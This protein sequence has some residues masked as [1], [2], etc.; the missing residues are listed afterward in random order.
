[1]FCSL[2]SVPFIL[3]LTL[4]SFFPE[5]TTALPQQANDSVDPNLFP[6]V[7]TFFTNF[8]PNNSPNPSNGLFGYITLA[9]QFRCKRE[10]HV[11][12]T[13]PI[14]GCQQIMNRNQCL[15][16]AYLYNGHDIKCEWD[17]G[18]CHP[19]CSC[20]YSGQNKGR[21][22]FMEDS[23]TFVCSQRRIMT[24]YCNQIYQKDQCLQAKVNIAG[25][26]V[27]C[28]WNNNECHPQCGCGY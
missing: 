5:H 8:N 2:F 18:H 12:T 6:Q 27:L 26:E 16:T 22:I 25:N 4:T 23:A 28:G 13:N 3:A 15:Q 14:T 19:G 17:H 20:K 11:I 10:N 24:T 21:G 9:D 7:N 1:M